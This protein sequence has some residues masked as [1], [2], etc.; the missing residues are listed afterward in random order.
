MQSAFVK[1]TQILDNIIIAHEILHTI[2]IK[3][4]YMALYMSNAFD[5]INWQFLL[6]MLDSLGFGRKWCK[7]IIECI[8]YA[9]FSVLLNGSPEGYFQSTRGLGKGD[10]LSP[11][12]FII[13]MEIVSRLLEKKAKL[14]PHP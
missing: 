10:L 12:L 2:R 6:S 13:C 7:L 1:D 9:Q 3:N 5:R 14:G 4:K 8:S 11:F